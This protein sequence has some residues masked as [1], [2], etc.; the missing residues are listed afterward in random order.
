MECR[1]R[2]F[3]LIH[4]AGALEVEVTFVEPRQGVGLTIV[5]GKESL[6]RSGRRQPSSLRW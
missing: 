6:G 3:I 4:D 2:D 5:V 1:G